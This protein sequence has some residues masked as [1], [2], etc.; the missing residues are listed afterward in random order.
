MGLARAASAIMRRWQLL[1]HGTRT[2]VL[3]A[4][5][6]L[7]ALSTVSSLVL[8]RQI[9][10]VRVQDGI[11]GELTQETQEFRRLASGNDPRTGEPFGTDLKAIYDVYFARNVPSE[12]EA[13]VA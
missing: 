12:G 6:V 13:L 8:V 11:T 4:F 9:L 10:V 2:R 1:L 5:V 3:L 7:L